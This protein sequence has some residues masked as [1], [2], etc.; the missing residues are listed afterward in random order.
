MG[1]SYVAEKA[2]VDRNGRRVGKD[3]FL[4]KEEVRQAC[5]LLPPPGCPRGVR[6]VLSLTPGPL[7]LVNSTPAF[8]SALRMAAIVSGRPA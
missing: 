7:P 2:R 1:P 3:A 6:G 8:S 5:F 4:Q